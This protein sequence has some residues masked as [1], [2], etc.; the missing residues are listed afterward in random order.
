MMPAPPPLLPR[1]SIAVT[2]S[3][4]KHMLCNR[5]TAGAHISVLRCSI[6]TGG[7]AL[8]SPFLHAQAAPFL[9]P[10]MPCVPIRSASSLIL[11]HGDCHN[12]DIFKTCGKRGMEGPTIA[13]MREALLR[14]GK[15]AARTGMRAAHLPLPP[16]PTMP[17]S[18]SHCWQAG[19]IKHLVRRGSKAI[20]ACTGPL[21]HTF[22]P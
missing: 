17:L 7:L 16:A 12:E 5:I 4:L 10:A 11:P 2:H 21:L 14:P 1:F 3:V 20:H 13:L 8:A 6:S 22:R 9:N 15:G 19:H 18:G